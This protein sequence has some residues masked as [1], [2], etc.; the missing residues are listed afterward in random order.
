MITVPPLGQIDQQL[1]AVPQL[2]VPVSNLEFG[3]Q[4]GSADTP[5]KRSPGQI[6]WLLSRPMHALFNNAKTSARF[7]ALEFNPE[8]AKP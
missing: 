2:I 6:D 4:A 8:K 7:I 3:V 1:H 5:L